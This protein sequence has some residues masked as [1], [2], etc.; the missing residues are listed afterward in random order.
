V[1]AAERQRSEDTA[2]QERVAKA[3]ERIADAAD[4]IARVFEG[5]DTVDKTPARPEVGGVTIA[6]D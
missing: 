5:A 6:E 1:N 2:R 3:V 4:R